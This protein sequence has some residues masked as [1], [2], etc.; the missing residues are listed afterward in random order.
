MWQVLD[1][2]VTVCLQVLLL[3]MILSCILK[4]Q[5]DNDVDEIEEE[6]NHLKND[7]EFLSRSERDI[8]GECPSICLSV[9]N[10]DAI[11][12][13]QDRLK[14]CFFCRKQQIPSVRGRAIYESSRYFLTNLLDVVD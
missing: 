1:N 3:A 2:N 6:D 14:T 7:E 12:T 10:E 4:K 11:F 9:V 8:Q 13:R 5:D